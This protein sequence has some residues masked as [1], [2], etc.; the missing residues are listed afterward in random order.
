MFEK[1]NF[2]TRLKAYIYC[3]IDTS[4][5]NQHTKFSIGKLYTQFTTIKEHFSILK[6]MKIWYNPQ[7]ISL[8]RIQ[9]IADFDDRWMIY[10]LTSQIST[11]QISTPLYQ[12]HWQQNRFPPIKIPSLISTFILYPVD[13]TIN[14]NQIFTLNNM[15]PV[16]IMMHN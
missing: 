9:N 16:D 11:P 1:D 2:C 8:L 7:S 10:S 3:T 5:E 4:Q 14:I 15:Q 13:I 6:Y 12:Q